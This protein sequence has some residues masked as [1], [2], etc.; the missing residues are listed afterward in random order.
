MV[1]QQNRYLH[2]GFGGYAICGIGVTR[3]DHLERAEGAP[4]DEVAARVTHD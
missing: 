4:T 2:I 3:Y 1:G